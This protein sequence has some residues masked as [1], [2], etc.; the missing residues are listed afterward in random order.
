MNWLDR[1]ALTQALKM[2]RT[3]DEDRAQQIEL[4]LEDQPWEE[5]ATFAS[6]CCQTRSLHL[7][8][9]QSPPCCGDAPD[10]R[11][12]PDAKKLLQ[13][14]LAAGIRNIIPIR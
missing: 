11:C 13:Q 1:A 9:W 12:D 6:F 4:M 5:V 8:P 3:E 7:D 2:C 14:M 10:E